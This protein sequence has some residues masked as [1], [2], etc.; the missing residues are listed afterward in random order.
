MPPWSNRGAIFPALLRVARK[1]GR[2]GASQPPLTAGALA[3]GVIDRV[4]TSNDPP[5][6]LPTRGGTWIAAG[7][8]RI[9]MGRMPNDPLLRVFMCQFFGKLVGS[10]TCNTS[11][12]RV[13]DSIIEDMD[14][15]H[16]FSKLSCYR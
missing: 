14:S 15:H 13:L 12:Y 8:A 6:W 1:N 9:P 10:A 16:S 4:L 2:N 5:H 7:R 11:C 3:V